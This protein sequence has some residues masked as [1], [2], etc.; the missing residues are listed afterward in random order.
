MTTQDSPR[1]FAPDYARD[2][3]VKLRRIA[4]DECVVVASV[5]CD[6]HTR[7]GPHI[8]S[9]LA[10][11]EYFE[12]VVAREVAEAILKCNAKGWRTVRSNVGRLM[13]LDREWM[14]HPIFSESNA[15]PLS[16]AEGWA[17][18]LL[19]HY[20]NKR[21]IAVVARMHGMM[22]DRPDKAPTFALDLKLQLQ[23]MV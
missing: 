22:I 5:L 3:Q 17:M 19:K 7:P 23:E 21:L 4:D 10:F 12:S 18:G 16:S 6:P 15:L 2:E 1:T 14:N 20:Q 11:N 13:P 8:S 9:F